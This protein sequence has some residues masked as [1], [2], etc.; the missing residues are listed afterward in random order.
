MDVDWE[1]IVGAEILG[2]LNPVLARADKEEL[3]WQTVDEEKIKS[4]AVHSSFKWQVTKMAVD[5]DFKELFRVDELLA[6]SVL[7]L[8]EPIVSVNMCKVLLTAI[9]DR[10]D[11]NSRILWLKNR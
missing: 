4:L 9:F 7:E 10:T 2:S 6:V 11:K 3:P 5:L 8:F 1:L